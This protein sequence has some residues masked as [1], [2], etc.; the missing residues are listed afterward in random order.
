MAAS[1]DFLGLLSEDERRALEA[2]ATTRQATRGQVLLAQGQV[3]DRV[4]VLRTGHAKVVASGPEGDEVVLTFRG[5]GSL[6]GEQAVVDGSPRAAGVIAIEPLEM[7]IIPASA[8]RNYLDERPQVAMK[9]VSMLSRRLR[10]SDRQLVRFATSDTLGRVSARLVELCEHHGEAASD[11]A[12][13]VTLPLT[14]EDLAGWTGSS[15]ESTAKALRVL[16]R[17]DW[18]STGR[19][20]ITVHDLEALRQRAG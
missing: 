19:R 5:P 14:Q 13:H 1:L 17:L 2:I 4:L 8:F 10:D 12:V 16:R 18:I 7:L 3:P 11:G 6:L 9:L 15:L 20:S